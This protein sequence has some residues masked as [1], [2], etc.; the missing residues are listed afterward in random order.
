MPQDDAGYE[1]TTAS[2]AVGVDGGGGSGDGGGF[3]RSFARIPRP[4]I[5]ARGARRHGTSAILPRMESMNSSDM[6]ET[7]D[8]GSQSESDDAS[9]ASGQVR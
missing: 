6:H 2:T 8:A 7:A 3:G 1:S 9:A 5:E 4:G